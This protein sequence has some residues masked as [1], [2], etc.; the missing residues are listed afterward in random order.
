MEEVFYPPFVS[1]HILCYQAS[2]RNCVHL[3][4]RLVLKRWQQTVSHRF[5]T[6]SQQT[7]VH[8][9][10]AADAHGNKQ[11]NKQAIGYQFS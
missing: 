11:T 8:P 10:L 7:A 9:W 3:A 5:G 6:I 2:C 4:A 1:V